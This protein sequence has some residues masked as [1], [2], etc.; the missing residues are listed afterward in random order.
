MLQEHETKQDG[1][2]TKNKKSISDLISGH[3]ALLKQR[4]EKL[5]N[6]LTSVKTDVEELKE[7]LSFTQNDIGQRFLNI[8]EKE[9]SLGKEVIS[10]KEDVGVIQTTEPTWALE[11]RRKLVDIEDRSRRNNLQILLGTK[12]NLRESWEECEKNIYDLL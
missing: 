3:Q 7:S 1:M 11:I 12:E 2:F 4:L 9:Q 10:T 8:N 5:C 6:S